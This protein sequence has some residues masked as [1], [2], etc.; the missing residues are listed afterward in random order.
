M[1]GDTGAPSEMVIC[2]NMNVS[3]KGV[4]SVTSRRESC[5]NKGAENCSGMLWYACMLYIIIRAL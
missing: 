1:F 2:V 5:F 3:I 4:N